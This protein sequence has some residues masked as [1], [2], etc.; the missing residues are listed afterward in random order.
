MAKQYG[1]SRRGFMGGLTGIGT[2]FATGGARALKGIDIGSERMRV[3]VL[4]DVHIATPA[5]QPYFENA[6]R[7]FD[8]WK[9][10][11]VVACGDLADYGMELQLQLLD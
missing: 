10:D 6:L 4:A 5:Q 8:E 2:M 7:K 3:G 11:G 1:V 9:V